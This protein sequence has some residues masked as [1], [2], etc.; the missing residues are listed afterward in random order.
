MSPFL[1]HSVFFPPLFLFLC[2]S[3]SLS[4]SC[5][6]LSS[7]LVILVFVSFFL[8][9]PSC[10]LFHERRTLENYIR[11]FFPR[12][13]FLF[14][15]CSVLFFFQI[16]LSYLCFFPVLSC[17][18]LFNMNGFRFQTSQVKKHTNFWSNGGLQQSVFF[19]ACVF[20]KSEKSSH[21]GGHCC[22]GF[23]HKHSNNRYF[24]TSFRSKKR[25]NKCHF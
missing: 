4:L 15:W 13:F 10:L 7:F 23:F 24:C 5:S 1:S 14:C 16:P 2:L 9:L 17:V 3:L 12:Q 22:V 21:F 8:F 6:F 18:F 20:A 11:R 25:Q 19:I